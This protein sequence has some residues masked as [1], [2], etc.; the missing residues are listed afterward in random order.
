M[1]DCYDYELEEPAAELEA[2]EPEKVAM[3]FRVVR[4]KIK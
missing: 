1:C 4:T 2:N 3:P